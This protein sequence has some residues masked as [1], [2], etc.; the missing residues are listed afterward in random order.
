MLIAEPRY[1]TGG[2]LRL[3]AILI[4]IQ[5]A[6]RHRRQKR[7]CEDRAGQGNCA[8]GCRI[9]HVCVVEANRM[10]VF[11]A[12]SIRVSS[13]YASGPHAHAANGRYSS[14]RKS[15]ANKA[16]RSGKGRRFFRVC[17]TSRPA[18]LCGDGVRCRHPCDFLFSVMFATPPGTDK[19]D[20]QTDHVNSD[21][22]RCLG[23]REQAHGGVA[24]PRGNLELIWYGCDR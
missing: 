21:G 6:G 2:G 11:T 15:K 18:G 8:A 14:T 24:R 16:K 10:R 22:H 1:L 5:T 13:R 9:L 19:V 23:Q 3:A 7:G 4:T 17:V 20:S 12:E